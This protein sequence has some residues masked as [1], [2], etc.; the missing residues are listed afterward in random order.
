MVAM[1]YMRA[2]QCNEDREQQLTGHLGPGIFFHGGVF[3]FKAFF[4]ITLPKMAPRT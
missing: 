2:S 3:F 4:F 1:L